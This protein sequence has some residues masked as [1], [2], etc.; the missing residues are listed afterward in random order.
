MSPPSD[1]EPPGFGAVSPPSDWELPGVGAVS[2][3]ADLE[4]PGA[5]AV[6]PP[7]D[8]ELSGSRSCVFLIRTGFSEHRV[9]GSVALSVWA[10]HCLD[11]DMV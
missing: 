11:L 2:P 9:V 3:P 1:W 8:W 10:L 4:L 6:S 5:G 7:P